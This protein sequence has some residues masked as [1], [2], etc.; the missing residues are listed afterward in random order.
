M[1]RRPNRAATELVGQANTASS[2]FREEPP[3][4]FR[5]ETAEQLV[6]EGR[7]EDLLADLQSLQAG[8]VG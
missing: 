8:A 7:T 5:F 6:S 3:S 1:E 4:A 2:W